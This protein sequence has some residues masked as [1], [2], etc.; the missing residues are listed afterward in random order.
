MVV[1]AAPPTVYYASRSLATRK[2]LSELAYTMA[3]VWRVLEGVLRCHVLTI[4]HLPYCRNLPSLTFT[5]HLGLSTESTGMRYIQVASV[6]LRSGSLGLVVSE[7]F[8]QG[9]S[10][11]FE[12]SFSSFPVVV[13]VA[14]CVEWP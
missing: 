6:V 7:L 2:T 9:E 11:S 10:L 3:D 12:Y 4:C 13:R 14:V 8:I 1:G 5:V